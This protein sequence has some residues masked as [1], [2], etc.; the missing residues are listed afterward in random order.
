MHYISHALTSVYDSDTKWF[1]QSVKL[2]QFDV[3]KEHWKASCTNLY[4]KLTTWL[5]NIL[6]DRRPVNRTYS[7]RLVVLKKQRLKCRSS[8]AWSPIGFLGE[9]VPRW[10]DTMKITTNF[11]VTVKHCWREPL[12]ES[13]RHLK[14]VE[15]NAILKNWVF[16][17][18]WTRKIDVMDSKMYKIRL[19][20]A[21]V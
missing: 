5:W 16:L 20:N 10:P 9:I 6:F 4:E 17:W 18:N 8:F 7:S 12:S 14:L 21:F 1:C 15:I 3:I 2:K 11:L 19:Y 13:L